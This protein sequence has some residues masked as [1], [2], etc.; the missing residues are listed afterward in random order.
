MSDSERHFRRSE[1]IGNLAAALAKAQGEMENAK[2]DAAN[3]YF[4][5]KYA[6]LAGVMD[7]A[8]KPLADNGLSVM[9]FPRSGEET[10]EVETLLAHESGEW[11]SETLVLPA[12][13]KAKDGLR[14]DAQSI[15]SAIT[16]ARRYAYQSIV[17]IATEDDDG[18]AA[19]AG[20]QAQKEAKAAVAKIR[21][22]TIEKLERIAEKGSEA[23]R[24]AWEALPNDIRRMVP[25]KDWAA[26][27]DFAAKHQTDA[28][29]TSRKEPAHA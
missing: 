22:Q 21:D 8:R 24:A 4:S 15:G 18:N 5:S 3:P 16:Y 7:V 29:D 12:L 6:D 20:A 17:G 26:I 10:I 28:L 2:K 14:F 13:M 11:V 23:L 1:N 19:A 25:A 9:Q 27:K